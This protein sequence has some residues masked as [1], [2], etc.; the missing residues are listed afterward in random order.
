MNA[1]RRSC[2][3]FS[4]MGSDPIEIRYQL[5]LLETSGRK[6]A[7]LAKYRI[8]GQNRDFAEMIKVNETALHMFDAELGM[9]MRMLAN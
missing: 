1:A 4:S 9:R 7:H 3:H 8:N 5:D 2:E 6:L